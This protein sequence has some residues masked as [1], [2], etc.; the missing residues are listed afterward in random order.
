M[1]QSSPADVSG[2]ARNPR[3]RKC[4]VRVNEREGGRALCQAA[5]D[6]NG[7]AEVMTGF[8]G[9]FCRGPYH[10]EFGATFEPRIFVSTNILLSFLC[11]AV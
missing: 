3:K 8:P 10:S 1:D 6:L 5:S 7:E 4:G 11:L 2:A 9:M